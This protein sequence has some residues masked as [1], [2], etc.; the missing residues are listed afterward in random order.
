MTKQ[1]YPVL[2]LVAVFG[3]AMALP[4]QMQLY[5]VYEATVY[6]VMA[7]LALSLAFIWGKGG[8]MCLG[9]SAFFGLGAYAY[10]VAALNF[11]PG[12]VA[13]LA[14]VALPALGA[15]LLGYFMFYGRISDIYVGVIT[16]AVT[17]ILFNLMN[18]TSGPHYHIGQARLGGF[19]GITGIP[20]LAWPDGTPLSPAALFRLTAGLLVAVLAALGL[21]LRSPAGKLALAVRE[22]EH[23]AELLGYNV[24]LSKLSTFAIGGAVA[25]LAG[26]LFANWGA[27]VS[28]TVFALL[29]S[30]QIIIWVIVGGRGT[31]VGPI[32]GCI[33]LQWATTQLGTQQVVQVNLVLG[34]VLSAFVLLVPAGLLPSLGK[35][36]RPLRAARAQ[37]GPL[38][39]AGPQRSARH[40]GGSG[41]DA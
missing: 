41:H 1:Q 21:Y 9:Q 36:V 15:A 17:L 14:A 8:I 33:A 27:F 2:A 22:N 30:A 32:L 4:A 29:Q 5:T 7:I 31:L 19:N 20:T 39:A 10:A 18:S 28:P 12:V 16:L 3:L 35:W 6:L 24:A 40:E 23:R 11:G 26:G 13:C 25:G 38:A 34:V 37:G